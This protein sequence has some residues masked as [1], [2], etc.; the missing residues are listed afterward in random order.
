MSGIS[1]IRIA[2]LSPMPQTF[3]DEGLSQYV[4]E[5]TARDMRR[6]RLVAHLSRRRFSYLALHLALGVIGWGL[7]SAAIWGVSTA[8]N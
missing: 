3:N 6:A 4:A 7:L 2:G 1:P 5:P 8:L